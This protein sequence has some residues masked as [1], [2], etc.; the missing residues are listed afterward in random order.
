[1]I[2]LSINYN[3]FNEVAR[4]G[5]PKMN[6]KS[7]E[8][9]DWWKEQKKRCTE[10]YTVGGKYMP[11]YQYGYINFGTIELYDEKKGRKTQGRPML[12]DVEWEVFKY[13]DQAQ[14]EKKGF[15]W[16]TGRRGGKS[17]ISS[18]CSASEYTFHRDNEIV[19][20]GFQ[21]DYTDPLMQKVK[22]HLDGLLDAG[23]EFYQKRIKDTVD[24]E[25]RAGYRVKV[26]DKN[27][28]KGSNSR[29]FNIVFK[30][31]HTAANGKTPKLFIFE[32]IGM[33]DN[34]EKSYSSS[35]PC[36]KEGSE[37]FGTPILIGT[38]GDM[39]R[40][41]ISA[42]KMFYDPEPHNLLTFQDTENDPKTAY[43]IPAQYVLND[44][45]KIVPVEEG[46]DGITWV[47][48]FE[49]AD[50]ALEATRTKK[51]K[52]KDPSK[53]IQEIQY[54]PKNAS[55]AFMQSVGNKFPQHLIQAQINKII[56]GKSDLIGQVGELEYSGEK[57]VWKPKADAVE[58][59]FPTNKENMYGTTVVYEHPD[60]NAPNMLYIAG[61][62]PY[63]FDDA[64][65]SESL[66]ATTVFKRFSSSNKTYDWPVATY[67]GRP[68]TSDVYYENM[69][70]LLEYYNAMCL[71]ENMVMGVKAWYT[72]NKK[73][74]WLAPQ[75][76]I[77]NHIIKNSVVDR[78][79]GIHM[80]DQI[81][82]YAEMKLTEWLSEEYAPGQFNV[83]KIYSLTLLKELLAYNARG[84]F[85]RVDS[86]LLVMLYK[87]ELT[88]VMV[89][90][91]REIKTPEGGLF[92]D[93]DRKLKRG[94]TRVPEMEH[95]SGNKEILIYNSS[96]E[97]K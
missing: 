77:L 64:E 44:H 17:Y 2:D 29:I 79:Y 86:M 80:N 61:T 28:V 87:E 78:H 13:I 74:R 55:E 81:R 59:D 19:I 93:W 66:G 20:G 42:Q 85:D 25:L 52:S 16:I 21:H 76:Q 1:M 53:I 47:T 37:W 32:E 4:K 96:F 95:N 6:P 58:A 72:H 39:D 75:P 23:P 36:W 51:K 11:G 73:T 97:N 3:Y 84:N 27:M 14:K 65:T 57:L 43:F 7:K 89:N 82:V 60:L 62:D 83:D 12:R 49:T 9:R 38:G 67:Y 50:A 63:A 54:Y 69:C 91:T 34:L 22:V 5:I 10:G 70:K 18:W 30:Q 26:G 56:S 8:Y 41:S 88:N 46:G 68:E 33:F 24:K 48:N 40:G 45:K 94:T 15:F 92:E 90:S 71:H 31:S 35:E